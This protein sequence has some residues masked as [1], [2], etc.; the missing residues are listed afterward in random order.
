MIFRLRLRYECRVTTRLN[1][2]NTKHPPDL[3]GHDLVQIADGS[4]ERKTAFI[5]F[6][7]AEKGIYA[8]VTDKWKY[9]YSAGD[10][11]EFLFDRRN[12]PLETQNVANMPMTDDAQVSLKHILLKHL[13]SVGEDSAVEGDDWKRYDW[14]PP[15]SPIIGQRIYDHPWADLHIPGYS[16]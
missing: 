1:A 2:A 13:R 9:A 10:D 4:V 6:L 12:D 5:Q 7:R 16:E 11:L 3:D 15:V 14:T 8:V